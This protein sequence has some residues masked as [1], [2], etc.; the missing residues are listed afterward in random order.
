[1]TKRVDS[2]PITIYVAIAA[3][4]AASVATANYIKTHYGALPT[5]VRADKARKYSSEDSDRLAYPSG[6]SRVLSVSRSLRR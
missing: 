4:Y 2:E 5:R 3:T 1:V 6:R